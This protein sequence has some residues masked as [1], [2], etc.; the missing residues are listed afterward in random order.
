VTKLGAGLAGLAMF[1]AT[2]SQD[3]PARDVIV[4]VVDRDGKPVTDL[5]SDEFKALVEGQDAP[6]VSVARS[7]MP[8]SMTVV[9]DMSSSTAFRPWALTAGPSKAV[10]DGILKEAT[11]ADSARLARVGGTVLFVSPAL[12]LT[13][14]P[15]M[16]RIRDALDCPSG[17][18][19]VWDA[20]G[21]A[22]HALTGDPHRRLVVLVTDGRA[23]T[24]TMPVADASRYALRMQTAVSV[25]DVG[26]PETIKQW[27]GETAIIEPAKALRWL[28]GTTGGAYIP[29]NP[30]LGRTTGP[31]PYTRVRRAIA[32]RRD[33]Y[34]VTLRLPGGAAGALSVAVTRPGTIVLAP[35]SLDPPPVE[36]SA[37]LLSRVRDFEKCR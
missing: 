3:G 28:A 30:A 17:G 31:E 8:V 22:V 29:D 20:V 12:P 2:A 23:T 6:I 16:T 21:A 19:P 34:S 32:A 7:E 10:V 37:S 27:N 4:S 36:L 26:R 1:A 11:A 24:T 5:R 15:F 14:Q 9:I 33:A 35:A 13:P 25:I 18:S